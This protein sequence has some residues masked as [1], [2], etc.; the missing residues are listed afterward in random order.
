MST[1]SREHRRLLENTV[2]QARAIAE[3][4][5]RKVL[6]DQYA[7]HHYEPWPHMKDGA[8]DSP[9]VLRDKDSARTLRNRLRAHGRQLGD[10]RDPKLKT[11]EIDHLV[12]ACAYA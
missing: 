4:G 1:L 2:A 10:R 8:G 9:E 7:V 6:G 11:Q 12:Q 5:A 3:G